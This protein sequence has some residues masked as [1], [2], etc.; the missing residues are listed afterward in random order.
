M[1]TLPENRRHAIVVV[2]RLKIQQQGRETMH[3]QGRGS[4]RRALNAM[5]ATVP[6]NPAR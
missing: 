2:H 6:Q 1:A 4:E 3:A 5:R